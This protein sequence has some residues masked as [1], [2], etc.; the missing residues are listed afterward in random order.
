MEKTKE[1]IRSICSERPNLIFL[2]NKSHVVNEYRIVGTTMWT[3]VPS[4]YLD[5]VEAHMSDYRRISKLKKSNERL[6]LY[7]FFIF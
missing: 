1:T 7:L 5:H 2:D 6:F 3:D 4:H